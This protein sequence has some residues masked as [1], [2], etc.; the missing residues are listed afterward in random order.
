MNIDVF[1]IR[2][3]YS[4]FDCG[5]R[6]AECDVRARGDEDVL[7]WMEATIRQCGE[8]HH[9]RSPQCYPTELHDLMIPMT[10][11]D[12]IGGPKLQ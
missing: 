12:R 6:Q 2:V 8:D 3:R 4:C 1:T 10:S 9:R 5:L 7:V 11:V